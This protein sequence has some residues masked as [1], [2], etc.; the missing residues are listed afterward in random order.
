MIRSVRDDKY[1][2]QLTQ[3]MDFTEWALQKFQRK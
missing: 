3:F 2:G 1:E